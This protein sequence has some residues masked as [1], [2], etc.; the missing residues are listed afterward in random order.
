MEDTIQFL[1]GYKV[2][3]LTKYNAAFGSQSRMIVPSRDYI[4]DIIQLALR[5]SQT[6]STLDIFKNTVAEFISAGFE[7]TEHE[8][9]LK[10]AEMVAVSIFARREELAKVLTEI[11]F[12]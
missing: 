4:I 1:K 3:F 6:A 10:M 7:E 5:K 11:V 8:V 12:R 2:P 9:D